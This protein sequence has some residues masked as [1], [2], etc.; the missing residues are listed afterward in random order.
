M[1]LDP[2]G[3]L[4]VKSVMTGIANTEDGQLVRYGLAKE[5]SENMSSTSILGYVCAGPSWCNSSPCE[6][7]RLEGLT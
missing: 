3:M 6:S 2:N 1:E 5:H 4:S 7:E